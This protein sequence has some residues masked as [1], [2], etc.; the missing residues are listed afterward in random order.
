MTL[1]DFKKVKYNKKM[2]DLT[3]LLIDLDNKNITIHLNDCYK[4]P[5]N[6]KIIAFK[7]SCIFY[8]N[9]IKEFNGYYN[10]TSMQIVSHNSYCFKIA[11]IVDTL[12][13]VITKNNCVYCEVG[14]YD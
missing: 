4:N 8:N 7:K 12:L 10:C 6:S 11:F 14:Y 9:M 13:F 1:K 5:S 3:K 2:K